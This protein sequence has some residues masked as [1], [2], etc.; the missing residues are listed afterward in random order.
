MRLVQP[1]PQHLGAYADALQRGWSPDN[2]RP[3]AATELLAQ[4]QSDPAA[5]LR[6]TDDPLGLGPP[7][8]L[9]DG[10]QVPRLPGIVRWIWDEAGFAGTINLRWPKDLGALPPRV[11]GHIGYAVVPWRQRRGHATQALAL[12]LPVA[13]AQGL[14]F[15]EITTDAANLASQKVITAN[16]GV[17][18]GPF[19]KPAAYGGA[20]S[21]RFRIDLAG[22]AQPG[23]GDAQ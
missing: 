19:D 4:L 1:A 3:A 18:V 6:L 11:L 17:L 16:G 9:P 20:P 15:V 8:T 13:R 14:T 22:G 5:Y 12:M 10:T 23:P 7:V 21:L 2:T